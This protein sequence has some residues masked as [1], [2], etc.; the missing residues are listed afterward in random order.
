MPSPEPENTMSHHA[1]L[2]RQALPGS[3]LEAFVAAAYDEVL[4]SLCSASASDADRQSF[5]LSHLDE[6]YPCSEWRFCGSLGFGGKFRLRTDASA[7][8]DCYPEDETPE[9]RRTIDSANAALN[10]LKVRFDALK[11]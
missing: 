4:V 6:T 5:I 10:A 2:L 3:P 11:S 9:R 7:C 1:T 8:V